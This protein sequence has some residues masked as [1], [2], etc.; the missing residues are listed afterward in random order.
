MLEELACLTP[1]DISEFAGAVFFACGFSEVRG[2]AAQGATAE[3]VKKVFAASCL[4][5]CP[6]PPEDVSKKLSLWAGRL[7]CVL[8]KRGVSRAGL[9]TR[10]L[11]GPVC[12]SL[13]IDAL[14]TYRDA[15]GTSAERD[16]RVFAGYFIR[17]MFHGEMRASSRASPERDMPVKRSAGNM[18]GIL[19]SSVA[20]EY[21]TEAERMFASST[22]RV[23][24]AQNI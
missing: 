17:E 6:P 13:G 8:R 21:E 10:A 12:E 14:S 2:D 19:A 16:A 7:R 15:N 5:S 23:N 11:L 9:K 4:K 20:A 18:A 24:A 1:G 3:C 22:V